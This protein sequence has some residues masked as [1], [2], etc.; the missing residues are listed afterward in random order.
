MARVSPRKSKF[1]WGSCKVGQFTTEFE[2]LCV[3]LIADDGP[4][5]TSRRATP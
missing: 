3:P 5:A 4:F 1:K 2:G